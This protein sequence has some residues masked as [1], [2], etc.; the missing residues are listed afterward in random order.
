MI[1]KCAL[2]VLQEDLQIKL[3]APLRKIYVE[4]GHSYHGFFASLGLKA[5]MKDNEL[6]YR[7]SGL[8]RPFAEISSTA[9]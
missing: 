3:T 9:Y 4:S 8:S 5:G 7:R 6:P 2:W 1:Y